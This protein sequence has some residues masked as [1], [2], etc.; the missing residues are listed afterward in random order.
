MAMLVSC[1]MG[2][3]EACQAVVPP[4]RRQSGGLPADDRDVMS[5]ARLFLCPEA[6]APGQLLASRASDEVPP[7]KRIP[8]CLLLGECRIG[9]RAWNLGEMGIS[10][11][12]TVGLSHAGGSQMEQDQDEEERRMGDQSS[13]RCPPVSV[14]SAGSVPRER[15]VAGYLCT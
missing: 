14:A 4:R 6:E 12:R 3:R 11:A 10:P 13:N 7:H 8:E 5:L 1:L 2:N 9:N 15:G